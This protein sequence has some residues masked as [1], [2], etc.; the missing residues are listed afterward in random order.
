MWLFAAKGL[1][2]NILHMI[3]HSSFWRNELSNAWIS[4][5]PW[6]IYASRVSRHDGCNPWYAVCIPG[7]ISVPHTHAPGLSTPIPECGDRAGFCEND[8]K[9]WEKEVSRWGTDKI[10]LEWNLF[11]RKI[12]KT[13]GQ[14][15]PQFTHMIFIT[16]TCHSL[17]ITGINWTRT[18]PASNKAS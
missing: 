9:T 11:N 15:N 14:V 16:Y 18:W 13:T 8:S 7:S 1:L 12:W 4:S 10:K 17:H 6:G 3:F 2:D 5:S